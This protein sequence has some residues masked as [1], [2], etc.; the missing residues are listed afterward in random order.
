VQTTAA[1]RQGFVG[2]K[3]SHRHDRGERFCDHKPQSWLCR[4]Q[5]TVER[6]GPFRENE[7]GVSRL[8]NANE[9]LNR[10]AVDFFLINWDYIQLG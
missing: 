5:I 8:E 3:D 6:P 1:A 2:A 7:R 4:L 10:A 9:G